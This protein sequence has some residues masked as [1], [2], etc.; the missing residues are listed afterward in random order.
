MLKQGIEQKPSFV[1]PSGNLG[2]FC[3]GMIASRME[4][5]VEKFIIANNSNDP[6][7]RYLESK[8]Y[9]VKE[10]IPT[11]SNAMDVGSP[12]NFPRALELFENSWGKMSKKVCATSF[13]DEQTRAEI[14]RVY[15]EYNYVI[16]PHTA[17]GFLALEKHKE[18][19]PQCCGVVLSTAHPAKF[20]ETMQEVLPANTVKIP[21]EL[22]ALINKEKLATSLS[23]DY[24]DFKN[25]LL[26]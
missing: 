4:I 7:T 26:S 2:N 11:I 23:S 8:E 5:P 18:Q 17:V 22:E 20:I 3:A 1:I 9:S 14:K 16:D 12:N 13:N 10:T 24:K 25:F 19:N 6:V 15:S 21:P